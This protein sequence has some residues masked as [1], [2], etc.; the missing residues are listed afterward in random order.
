MDECPNHGPPVF[1]SDT[2]V[3]VGI[4]DRAALTIPQGMEVVKEA[5]G[6]SDVR[7][8]SEVIPKGHIFGPYEGQISTQ[9]KSAG[10]FS[11]LVSAPGLFSGRGCGGHGGTSRGRHVLAQGFSACASGHADGGC[12]PQPQ[13]SGCAPCCPRALLRARLAVIRR[14]GSC[15]PELRAALLRILT[16][17]AIRWH[18]QKAR[19]PS[20]TWT[21]GLGMPIS[22]LIL[23]R[24]GRRRQCWKIGR[25]HV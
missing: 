22:M 6:E 2:P 12:C 13:P 3:P 7:C 4:P 9:D 15:R 25:A 19:P 5:S 10:F 14:A 16:G 20:S 1:V 21:W 23:G 18:S 8:I 17:Q 11:W 24:R